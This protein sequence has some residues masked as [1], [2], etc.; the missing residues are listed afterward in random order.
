MSEWLTHNLRQEIFFHSLSYKFQRTSLG[1]D[2][3]N[4]DN[5]H[6][7]GLDLKKKIPVWEF[8]S[9][10]FTYTEKKLRQPLEKKNF[11]RK[12][13]IFSANKLFIIFLKLGCKIFAIL[14]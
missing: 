14:E 7:L 11:E 1:Q 5:C 13:D 6:L 3:F 4:L 9:A 2:Q 8:Q 12:Y 10:L